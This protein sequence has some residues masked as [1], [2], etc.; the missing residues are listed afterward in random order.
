MERAYVK[1]KKTT[2]QSPIHSRFRSTVIRVK[3]T[4]SA[5]V[6]GILFEN[7]KIC[8]EASWKLSVIQI[9]SIYFYPKT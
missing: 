5:I 7:K 3:G 9:T 4:L 1:T 6:F 8:Q 2:K